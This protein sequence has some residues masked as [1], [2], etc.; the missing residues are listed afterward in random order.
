ME[1]YQIKKCIKYRKRLLKYQKELKKNEIL[2]LRK[3]DRIN[4]RTYS[5]RISSLESEIIRHIRF[6]DKCP[7][8]LQAA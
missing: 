4:Q 3:I 7:K 6:L 1:T 2:Y 8:K 5:R